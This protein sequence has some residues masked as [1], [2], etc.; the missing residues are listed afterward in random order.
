MP[1]AIQ[2]RK[3]L[4]VLAEVKAEDEVVAPLLA[5][6]QTARDGVQTAQ[7]AVDAE[8]EQYLP[9]ELQG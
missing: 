6:L 3:M 9:T 4:D 5:A 8:L 7:A 1:K 2:K